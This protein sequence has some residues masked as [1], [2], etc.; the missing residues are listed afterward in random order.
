VSDR[1]FFLLIFSLSALSV[2][3]LCM[4]LFG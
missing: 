2:F 1:R 4:A 3:L